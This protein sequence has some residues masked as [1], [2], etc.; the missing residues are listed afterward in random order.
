MY[1]VSFEL[2]W[3]MYFTRTLLISDPIVFYKSLQI[4][5]ADRFLSEGRLYESSPLFVYCVS[6]IID[7]HHHSETTRI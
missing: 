2:V 1:I 4:C 5:N 7:H 3:D 6:F